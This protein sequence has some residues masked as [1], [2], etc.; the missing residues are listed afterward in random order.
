MSSDGITSTGKYPYP[1][2]TPEI[3]IETAATWDSQPQDNL[4]P[5]EVD[6]KSFTYPAIEMAYN[7]AV[8]NHSIEPCA[9]IIVR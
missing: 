6:H 9:R 2:D 7:C 4:P 1:L 5:G 3:N 8:D